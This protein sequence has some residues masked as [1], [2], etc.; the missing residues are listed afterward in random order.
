MKDYLL[1]V[2]VVVK[3]LNLEI[4]VLVWQTIRQKNLPWMEE[5]YCYKTQNH[6][7]Y[8]CSRWMYVLKEQNEGE[9]LLHVNNK[10]HNQQYDNWNS[11]RI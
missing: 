3:T 5:K 2:H 4:H 10:T 9:N 11:G 7:M 1:C 6:L 8:V